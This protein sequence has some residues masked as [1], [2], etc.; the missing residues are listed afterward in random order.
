MVF[1]Q[2]TPF[3]DLAYVDDT[4]LI[5]GTAGRAEQL[6]AVV[7]TVASHC[8]L[9]LNWEKSV[10]LKSQASQNDVRNMHGDKVKEVMHAKYLG[11]FLSRNGTTRKDVTERFRK[12][13]ET[14]QHAASLLET[15]RPSIAV[16]IEDIQRCVR[17]ND[18]V[19]HGISCAVPTRHI[20]NRSL[21]LTEL[22]QNA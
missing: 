15:Y 5:A 17:S 9:Q 1:S 7:E 19:R 22:P 12:N 4:A 6:L 14:L 18:H 2:Q 13:Q 11:V 16:E 3:Y 21:P 8:N 10:L 20:P